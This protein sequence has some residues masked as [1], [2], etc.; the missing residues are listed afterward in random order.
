MLFIGAYRINCSVGVCLVLNWSA[1]G[2]CLVRLVIHWC[3]FVLVWWSLGVLLVS[4]LWL[5][6]SLGALGFGGFRAVCV[7]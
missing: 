1:I 3:L 5:G 7:R 4:V 6:R 2:A